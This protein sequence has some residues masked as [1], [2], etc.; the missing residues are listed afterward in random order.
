MYEC[1]RL[2]IPYPI[3]FCFTVIIFYFTFALI[4]SWI[5]LV[6]SKISITI[7]P[8][9]M[10]FSVFLLF[11]LHSMSPLYL[12]LNSFISCQKKIA[13]FKHYNGMRGLIIRMTSC[14]NE[15]KELKIQFKK[16]IHSN[17]LCLLILFISFL[18]FLNFDCKVLWKTSYAFI[19]IFKSHRQQE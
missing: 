5:P 16:Y 7:F 1:W 9:W 8:N 10:Y 3:Y 2:T 18:F 19:K 12:F 6:K 14:A 11:V 15:K 4:T 17:W 13:L